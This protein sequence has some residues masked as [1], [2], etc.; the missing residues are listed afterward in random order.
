MP[1]TEVLT[2]ARQIADAL[3]AA[4]GKEASFIGT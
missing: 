1:V 4:H 2:I 3:E